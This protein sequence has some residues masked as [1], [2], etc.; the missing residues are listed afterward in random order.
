MGTLKLSTE[1]GRVLE[2]LGAE[3]LSLF[4]SPAL[5]RLDVEGVGPLHRGRWLLLGTGVAVLG[6]AA[7]G[8]E[9]LAVAAGPQGSWPCRRCDRGAWPPTKR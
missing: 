1:A 8:L 5:V 9:G 4:R 3:P 7:Q 6:S 2:P